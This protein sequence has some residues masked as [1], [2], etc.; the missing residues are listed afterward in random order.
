MRRCMNY[1]PKSR[2]NTAWKEVVDKNVRALK[3]DAVVTDECK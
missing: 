1:E 2:P 3:G